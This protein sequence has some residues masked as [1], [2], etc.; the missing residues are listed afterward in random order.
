[1]S[2]KFKKIDKEFCLTD[3][4][5]NVYGYRLLTSGLLMDEVKKNPI[6][7]KMHNRDNGVVVRWEDFRTEAIKSLQNLSSIYHIHKAKL[8]LLKSK[9]D[10]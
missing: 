9:T 1:V 2:D 3:D 5:V 8:L 7:F 10:F 4:S 6:G